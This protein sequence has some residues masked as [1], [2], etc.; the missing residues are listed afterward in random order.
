MVHARPVL[1]GA[2]GVF[3]IAAP[4]YHHWSGGFHAFPV[5]VNQGLIFAFFVIVF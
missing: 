1:E 3:N 2:E 4:F 5:L